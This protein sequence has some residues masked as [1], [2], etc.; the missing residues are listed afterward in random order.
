MNMVD[1]AAAP[2]LRLIVVEDDNELRDILAT[3]LTL[4]GHIVR[5]APDAASLYNVLADFPADIVIL[6]L[7]LPGEDGISLAMRLRQQGR[8]CGIIMLTARG[9]VDDRILGLSSGADLY[10]VKPVDIREL[11]AAIRSLSRRLFIDKNKKDSWR[12]DRQ[13]ANLITP[14]GKAIALSAHECI[15][16]GTL[17]ASAGNSVS[18]QEI[19]AALHQPDD[20]YG[21]RR[22][23]T[24]I[25]R[26]RAKVRAV[27]PESA[28]PIRARHNLG[29]AFLA[30]VGTLG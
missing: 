16:V 29:Y 22:L 5:S 2:P 18:R 14:R 17:L 9:K 12:F 23:E 10:F 15:L 21:D 24:L 8:S 3:G 6:D 13:S 11:D 20:F 7:G 28:L 26:L 27:D 19:F 30:D 4:F 25:S 1:N